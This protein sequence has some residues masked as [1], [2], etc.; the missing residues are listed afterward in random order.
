MANYLK[1]DYLNEAEIPY[2]LQSY[3]PNF[4]FRTEMG[5]TDK[6][7]VPVL[8]GD[9]NIFSQISIHNVQDAVFQKVTAFI[10]EFTRVFIREKVPDR[11]YSKFVQNRDGLPDVELDWVFHYFRV[12]FL[13]SITEEDYYCITKYDGNTRKYES[14]IGPLEE[15]NY[16]AVAEEVMQEVG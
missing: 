13:F 4:H 15:N 1:E 3:L 8:N 11:A 5:V 10:S 16:R 6:E 7:E 2:N 14:K 12:S 9:D